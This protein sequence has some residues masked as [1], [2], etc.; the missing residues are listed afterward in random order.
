MAEDEDYG[1]KFM[2][3]EYTR[4]IDAYHELHRQ[5]DELI[6]F[7][8]AF[9]SLPVSVVAIFL[10]L[11]RFLQGPP[12]S[13]AAPS[14]IV[15]VVHALEH[16]GTF[17]SFLL[18]IVGGAVMMSMLNIR[19]EQYLYIKTINGARRYFKERYT[20]DAARYLVLPSEL[21]Q[22]TFGQDELSGRAFWDSMIVGSTTS[23]LLGF[24]SY[25][26]VAYAALHLPLLAV[27]HYLIL[28]TP[29]AVFGISLYVFR[30]F[31]RRQLANR[32]VFHGLIDISATGRAAAPAA[33]S[34]GLKNTPKG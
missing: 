23:V 33:P 7:Y 20:I 13:G 34:P 19:G 9:L 14:Q 10:A 26:L 5:K 15:D 4:I 16:A 30:G 32:L 6:K 3:Q 17:L 22:L 8:L 31:I 1:P 29:V 12:Q 28:A 27:P 21:N 25:E 18:V 24:L 2:L 11:S